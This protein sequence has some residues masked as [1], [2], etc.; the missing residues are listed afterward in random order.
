MAKQ[1]RTLG[2]SDPTEFDPI[3]R[4]V[5]KLYN[6]QPGL[7]KALAYQESKFNPEAMNDASGAYG[8]MQWMPKSAAYWNVNRS[9]PASSIEGAGRYMRHLIDMFNGDVGLALAAYNGGEGNV[10]Q[11]VKTGV[12]KSSDDHL[13]PKENIEYPEKVFSHMGLSYKSPSSPKNSSYKTFRNGSDVSLLMPNGEIQ[14]LYSPTAFTNYSYDKVTNPDRYTDPTLRKALQNTSSDLD[15]LDSSEKN[16]NLNET[17]QT[18]PSL[19]NPNVSND[20]TW[21][22]IRPERSDVYNIAKNLAKG[23]PGSQ[24]TFDY[25]LDSSPILDEQLLAKD[26]Q[27]PVTSALTDY[28]R[29]LEELGV[30]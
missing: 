22:L 27:K 23:F 7:L 25:N 21:S 13:R 16:Q 3:F 1:K 9:D 26:D 19:F 20:L 28:A 12:W 15:L 4:D 17:N 30:Y 11:W 8:L 14:E 10:K 2:P 18:F 29:I 24:A 6:L 5:E